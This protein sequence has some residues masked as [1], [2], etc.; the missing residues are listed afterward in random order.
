MD[1]G[2]IVEVGSHDELMN[3]RGK[4]A[5]MYNAQAQWYVSAATYWFIS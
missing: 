5:E 3:L 1:Q 2:N 4:Y